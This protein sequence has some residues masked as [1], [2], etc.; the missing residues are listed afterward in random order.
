MLRRRRTLQLSAVLAAASCSQ[1]HSR[2]QPRLWE[3]AEQ[4]AEE[5]L[6]TLSLQ[7]Q[8]VLVHGNGWTIP[9]PHGNY[10][11][12]VQGLPEKGIPWLKMSDSGNGYHNLLAEAVGTTTV[13][14]SSLAASCTWDEDMVENA[15]RALGYEFKGKSANIMLGPGLN[16]ERVSKGG[17]NW[18]YLSGEDPYLG[19]RLGRAFVRGVQSTGVMAVMKHFAFN[20]QETHR[21][22]ESS[23]VDDRTAWELYYP[24][25][26]AAV[27]EGVAGVMCPYNRVNGTYACSSE[28][29]LTR[30]L[31]EKMGYRGFVMSDW[32]A[33]SLHSAGLDVT[34]P[35][36][37][38]EDVLV[39]YPNSTR[40]AARHVLTSMYRMR[41]DEQPQGCIPPHCVHSQKTLVKSDEHT[42]LARQ[43]TASSIVLLK[44]DGILPFSAARIKKLHVVGHASE[45]KPASHSENRNGL[46]IGDV[47]SG[48]GSGHQSL[49]LSAAN[50][51]CWEHIRARARSAGIDVKQVTWKAGRYPDEDDVDAIIVLAGV[52]AIESADRADL[53]L[54]K[55]TERL[56]ESAAA[57]GKPVVVL[58]MI[59]GAVVMPWRD[60]A[61]AIAAMFYGG[62]ATGDAWADLI[63]GD[64]GPEGRL[65]IMMP[66]DEGDT[67]S[68]EFAS[69]VPYAEAQFTSYRSNTKRSSYAFG[70]GLSYTKFQ[71][72]SQRVSSNQD[73]WQRYAQAATPRPSKAPGLDVAESDACVTAQVLVVNTGDRS[74]KEVVQAYL[75]FPHA[76]EGTPKLR[77]AGF[78]KTKLLS[79]GEHELVKLH[80]GARELS[81]Y[82]VTEGWQVQKAVTVCLGVSSE[83]LECIPLSLQPARWALIGRTA[84]VVAKNSL[85]SELQIHGLGPEALQGYLPWISAVLAAALVLPFAVALQRL[86]TS[87]GSDSVHSADAQ[88]GTE[89]CHSTSSDA[90]DRLLLEAPA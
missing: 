68:P 50:G 67:I 18:E 71:L 5:K 54:W 38:S 51:T 48:G 14:P 84:N 8:T 13:W 64:V 66:H 31:R 37:L 61:A 72:E 41:L 2:F 9:F 82:T 90:M 79:P 52:Q 45:E 55:A 69:S 29:L 46:Q 59:P 39:K 81:I 85:P 53:H 12:Q 40:H 42:R 26:E 74:G 76:P 62:Q 24:P 57:T 60:R 4:L 73:I 7:E 35:S 30:D 32:F 1:C 58:M 20:E 28:D 83:K 6:E 89:D 63:F 47:Y 75:Q 11:G 43:L 49:L 44:N 88:G 78:R 16:V 3:E 10:I 70:H 27:D 80:F 15:S 87:R 33:R 22:W 17:R 25:F 56:I 34:M 77:L 65:P 21:D 23:N 19:S 36:G 86:R